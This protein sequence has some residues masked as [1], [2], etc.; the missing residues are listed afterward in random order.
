MVAGCRVL[1]SAA[2]GPAQPQR[3]RASPPRQD[4]NHRVSG[5]ELPGFVPNP[6]DKG[7]S[8]NSRICSVARS[9]MTK[10]VANQLPRI[11]LANEGGLCCKS[12]EVVA[13]LCRLMCGSALRFRRLSFQLGLRPKKLGVAQSISNVLPGRPKAFRTSG[14]KAAMEY[15]ATFAL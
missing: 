2:T 7:R 11:N 10:T 12:E 14:G 1:H 15:S 3:L 9:D 13:R 6:R 5:S 8:S 4:Q